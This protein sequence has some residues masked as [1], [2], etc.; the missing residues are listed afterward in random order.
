M[1]TVR[2]LFCGLLLCSSLVVTELWAQTAPPKKTVT[3][4]AV[5]A[6]IILTG[7]R[8]KGEG[9]IPYSWR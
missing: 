5:E 8:V 1:V 2:Y 6:P 9:A 4:E 7:Q 3:T